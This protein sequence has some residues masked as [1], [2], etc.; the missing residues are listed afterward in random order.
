[1][2]DADAPEE[3]SKEFGINKRSTLLEL[4]YFDMCSGSLIPDVMHDLLEGALQHVLKQLLHIL[5][6]EKKN[7]TVAHLNSKIEGMELGFMEDNRPSPVL[8]GEKMLRQNGN[9]TLQTY[10]LTINL[11]CVLCV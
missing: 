11:S 5:T 6:S 2:E 7:F 1:M 8:R 10:I 3:V 9:T 4:N